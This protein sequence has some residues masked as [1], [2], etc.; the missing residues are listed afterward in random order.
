MPFACQ[1]DGL[2]KRDVEMQHHA[3]V[4]IAVRDASGTAV[5]CQWRVANSQTEHMVGIEP[6]GPLE[7]RKL[8]IP[9]DSTSRQNQQKR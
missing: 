5:A 2:A 6:S 4:P 3:G 1:V 7:T 8:L 9:I